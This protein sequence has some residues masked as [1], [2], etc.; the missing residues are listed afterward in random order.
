[1]ERDFRF[2]DPSELNGIDP[3]AAARQRLLS[4]IRI[5]KEIDTTGDSL[6]FGEIFREYNRFV[7]LAF[8]RELT[9]EEL[10]H[11]RH[12]E[13]QI[14]GDLGP[15]GITQI[16]DHWQQEQLKRQSPDS[17]LEE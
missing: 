14:Q 15:T 6:L 4:N 11:T 1:M 8:R 12:L 17:P 16:F 3:H 13:A 7:E 10:I 9:D 5:L 2:S